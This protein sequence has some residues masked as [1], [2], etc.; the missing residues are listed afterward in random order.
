MVLYVWTLGGLLGLL[1]LGGCARSLEEKF[2]P[3]IRIGNQSEI[4]N[5]DPATMV[6][7]VQADVAGLLSDGLLE[8]HYLKRPFQLVPNLARAMPSKQVKDGK[9]IYTFQIRDDVYFHPCEC[10][11]ERSRRKLTAYDLEFSF[12]RLLDSKVGSRM[13]PDL[14]ELWEGAEAFFEASKSTPKTDYTMPVPALKVLDPYT[15]QITLSKPHSVFLYWLAN[16]NFFVVLREAVEFY[17]EEFPNHPIGT[18][19]YILKEW[20]R[21]SKLVFESNLMYHGRYPSEGEAGDKDQGLLEDAGKRLPLTEKMVWYHFDEPEPMWLKFLTGDLDFTS[22][23]REL[24]DT[25]I[26]Q[27]RLRDDLAQRGIVARKLQGIITWNIYV[28]L[29]H[30]HL[31]NL[32]LRKAIY[33]ALDIPRMLERLFKDRYLPSHSSVPPLLWPPDPE[34]FEHPFRGP[35]LERAKQELALAGYPEGKGLPP[36]KISTAAGSQ[37]R[38]WVEAIEQ[39]LRKIGIQIVFDGLSSIQWHKV[40]TESQFEMLISGSIGDYPDAETFLSGYYSKNPLVNYSKYHDAEYDRWYEQILLLDTQDPKRNQIIA[41]MIRKLQRDL[42]SF[43]FF[44]YNTYTLRYNTIRNF[45][46]NDGLFFPAKYWRK[47]RP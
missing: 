7:S 12:K 46:N 27:G 11:R 2:R 40:L 17:G 41:N 13:Y 1:F 38:Q 20:V 35:D 26:V 34:S 45:K 29:T 9:V 33:L 43:P 39:D 28:N 6:L 15:L 4:P 30:P 32:H 8:F 10:F 42:V 25:V 24:Y 19:P 14:K 16:P 37:P 3:E 36:L 22:I 5:L 47:A 31:Q 44:I 23:P 21:K 18:G